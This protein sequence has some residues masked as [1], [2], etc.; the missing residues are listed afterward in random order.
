[1]VKELQI[2]QNKK[3]ALAVKGGINMKTALTYKGNVEFDVVIVI[4]DA[5]EGFDLVND[6]PNEL[7]TTNDIYDV[8]YYLKSKGIQCHFLYDI[9]KEINQYGYRT[10]EADDIVKIDEKT[11]V[12]KRIGD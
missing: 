4:D 3:T 8:M 10:Y 6:I 12:T 1:M 11:G 7:E 9:D 2:A 5:P